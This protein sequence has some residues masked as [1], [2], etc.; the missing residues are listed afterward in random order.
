M[1]LTE[2]FACHT[3]CYPEWHHALPREIIDL[4]EMA[5][6]EMA[7]R[8]ANFEDIVIPLCKACHDL[9]TPTRTRI[10]DP[11]FAQWLRDGQHRDILPRWAA[12]EML[13]LY[14]LL[15]QLDTDVAL[16][17]SELSDVRDNA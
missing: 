16:L 17:R 15:F 6:I 12:I 10:A 3:P 11:V 14:Q 7:S 1:G 13:R 5:G 8:L 2:C 4:H 9:V